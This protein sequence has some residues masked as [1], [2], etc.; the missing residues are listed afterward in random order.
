[1]KVNLIGDNIFHFSYENRYKLTSSFIRMQEYYESP[2]N[3]I[4]NKYFTL[5]YYMDVYAKENYGVFSY[6]EDWNG[7]NIPGNSILKW[8]EQFRKNEPTLR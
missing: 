4:R 1:M 3:D 7:F 8:E 5:D 2:Y 6:F